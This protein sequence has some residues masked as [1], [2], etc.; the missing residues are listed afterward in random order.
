L[1]YQNFLGRELFL[2]ASCPSWSIPPCPFRTFSPRPPPK[3]SVPLVST[4][5]TP[6]LVLNNHIRLFPSFDIPLCLSLFPFLL[7]KLAAEFPAEPV[8]ALL[9]F[10]HNQP[11]A[12]GW[13]REEADALLR[14]AAR[15]RGETRRP[16]SA[17]IRSTRTPG[18]ITSTAW[19]PT[20]SSFR[21]A[22]DA[23]ATYRR[24]PRRH[25]TL[26][27]EYPLVPSYAR[28]LA[29]CHN[30]LALV[31]RNRRIARR[32]RRPSAVSWPSWRSSSLT[33]PGVLEHP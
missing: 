25:G 31:L 30:N 17:S 7:T 8:P 27:V 12:R 2:L 10:T 18:P 28:R 15:H 4:K 26:T 20:G 23:E 9:A 32:R 33:I 21:Q 1:L 13:G 24:A 16:S 6:P 19:A 11:G 14:R 29:A 22:R 3:S 5:P